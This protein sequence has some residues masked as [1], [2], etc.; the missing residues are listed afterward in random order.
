MSWSFWPFWSSY[1]SCALSP[2]ADRTPDMQSG[3]EARRPVWNG[4]ADCSNVDRSLHDGAH[5]ESG[6]D[7]ES[8][9]RLEIRR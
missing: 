6:A 9:P 5:I 3:D 8:A 1:E 4:H 7:R 2:N